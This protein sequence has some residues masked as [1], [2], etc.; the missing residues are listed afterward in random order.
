MHNN[1]DPKSTKKRI[2]QK[3]SMTNNLTKIYVDHRP[4]R[5]DTACMNLYRRNIQSNNRYTLRGR[6]TRNI[7]SRGLQITPLLLSR[8]TNE[9]SDEM[10]LRI[11]N[12]PFLSVGKRPFSSW[13]CHQHQQTNL[14]DG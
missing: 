2:L 10:C 9:R 12:N 8:R 1:V 6:T 11:F 13:I 5:N 7:C 3:Q 14:S 4:P